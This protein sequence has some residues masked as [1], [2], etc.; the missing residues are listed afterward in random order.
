MTRRETTTAATM[1]AGTE[2]GG[3]QGPGW[4]ALVLRVAG[5]GLLLAAG[6]NPPAR[7]ATGAGPGLTTATIGG[8]TVLTTAGGLTVYWF[9]PDTPTASAC[10]GS[11]A[12]YWPPV[13]GRATARPGLPGPVGTITRTGGARQLTYDGHP[14]YTYIGDTAPGQARGNNLN[15]NGGLWHDVPISR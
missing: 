2:H 5:A 10:Y 7:A 9:A 13:T 4:P 14:L 15:L 8:T 6:A 1:R 3:P 11:C 12:A